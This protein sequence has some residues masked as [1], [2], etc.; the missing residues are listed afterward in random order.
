MSHTEPRR[1]FLVTA[2]LPYSNGRLHVGHIAGAYLPADT[3]VRYRRAKGDDVLFICG[4][5]DNGVAALI[6]AKNEGTTVEE[7]TARYNKRQKAD[8]DSLGINFDIYG[9]TH[10][11]GFAETHEKLSQQFFVS[12]FKKGFFTKK[13]TD[14][15]YDP[16]AKQFLPDR[17]VQGTCPDCNYDKAYGDQCDNCGR[18][19]DPLKLKNPRSTIT[20]GVVPEVRSTSHW[21][22]RLDQ[23][24]EP[25]RKWLETKVGQWRPTVTNFALAQIEGGLPERAMTRDL[26]WGVPVPLDDPDAAGKALYVWFDAPIGYVTFTAAALKAGGH[27]PGEYSD[28]WKSEDSKIVHFI[29]ED[30]T[31]FHALTWPAM[32]MAEGT[33]QLPSNVVANSFLNFKGP[34]GQPDKIS[35]SRTPADSPVWVEEYAKRF[36]PDPLRGYLTSISPENART[37]FSL[38]EFF[39]HNDSV[40]VAVLGNF[41]NRWITFAHKYFEGKVPEKGTRGPLEEG[42][43]NA[44]KETAAK[45]AEHLDRFQFKVGYEAAMDLAR[46]GNKYFDDTK[47]FNTRTTDMAA[48]GT[49]INACIQ[50]GKALATVFGP[51]LPH[52]ARK[53]LTQLNLDESALRW[54]QAA[55]E[56]PA[57]HRLGERQILF[58]KFEQANPAGK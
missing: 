20:P 27:S 12:I 48:T 39:T 4:S 19:M 32:L 46:A 21:Y 38:E 28:W 31:V 3:Y 50:A 55:V 53:I 17:Y 54:D 29:G 30:N 7:L 34:D 58:K 35:K 49:A 25:L 6:A 1:R 18:S 14:Q 37:F 24:Q 13:T 16:V 5:D 22:L 42:L 2:A 41:I 15:L 10:Q 44:C 11:P 45:V 8:F 43:L 26:T 40:L 47:P 36:E 33:Y 51:F 52:T 57:G 56:L 23:F 9:G